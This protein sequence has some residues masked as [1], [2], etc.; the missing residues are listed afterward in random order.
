MTMATLNSSSMP[1]VSGSIAAGEEKALP[2]TGASLPADAAQEGASSTGALDPAVALLCAPVADGEPCGPDLELAGDAD[3]LNFFAQVEGIL[4]GSFFNALDGAPFD[5]TSVDLSRQLEAIQP[6]LDRTRDL[7]LLIV[8]AR[9]RILARDLAGFSA[10]LAAT[11]YWLDGFWDQVH[12]RSEGGEFMARA[13]AIGALDIPTVTFPLQY[14]P[15]FEARRLGIITYRSLLI[16]SDQVK[17]RAGEQKFDA[18]AILD[19]R[20]AADPAMLA[21]TRK[22]VAMLKW[23]IDRI[24][25][26]FAMHG[27]SAGLEILPPLVGEMQAFID[28]IEAAKVSAA[29]HDSAEEAISSE[30]AGPG[31]TSLSEA[32]DALAAIA[33]YYS[34]QEPSS[35]TLPLV[36]QAHQ[37]I[38]KSFVEVISI[39]IPAHMEKAAFQIG[40]DRVFELP[41]SKLSSLSGAAPLSTNGGGDGTSEDA[42]APAAATARPF[43]VGSRAQAIALLEQVQRYFRASEPSSPVPMLCERAR[44]LA[45]RDFMSVLRDV[46]PKV[47]LREFG[48]DK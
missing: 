35:P 24:R 29:E 40:G 22:H 45:E 6:L 18:A 32:R 39:L 9:L 13:N 42:L 14:A 46:L 31:P 10:S 7:R 33:D 28:P 26:A 30:L 19:A 3:Y 48:A 37:L 47:A 44:A 4:P 11:A 36:R 25:N 1:V 41:V 27:A 15:L 16:A 38:G 17:P 20:G 2:T 8:Q 21:A 5:S 12:P 34:R 23:A 43:Q